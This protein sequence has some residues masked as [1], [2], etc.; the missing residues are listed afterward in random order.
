MHFST[1]LALLLLVSLPALIYLG[2]PRRGLNQ[3]REAASLI[4]R[5][6]LVLCV[7]L[8]L[9]GLELSSGSGKGSALGVVFLVDRSDSIP[10]SARPPSFCL[11]VKRW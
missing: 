4:V 7:V 5:C 2:W 8:S 9:G 1:P 6:L 10:E 3:R 11:G